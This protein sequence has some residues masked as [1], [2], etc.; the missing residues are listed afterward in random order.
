M[1]DRSK[2]QPFLGPIALHLDHS[3]LCIEALHHLISYLLVSWIFLVI[4]L[5]GIFACRKSQI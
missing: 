3:L 1:V 4:F 5:G 2:H